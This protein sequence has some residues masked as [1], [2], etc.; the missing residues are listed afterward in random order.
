MPRTTDELVDEL[1]RFLP[2]RFAG[3]RELLAPVAGQLAHVLAVAELDFIEHT[4]V[5][6]ARGPWLT[7][8]ARGYGI[9]R[10]TGELDASVRLRLRFVE[11]A[12]TKPAIEGAVN[13][14]LAPYTSS[15]CEL[16]EHWADGVACDASEVEAAFIVDVSELYG[17]R[18]AFT[19]IVPLVADDP[20]HPVYNTIAAEVGR[21]KAAGVRWWMILEAP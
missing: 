15:T 20:T 7:L 8:L 10:A 19:L 2:E 5:T 17:A 9:R 11:D 21:L 1:L 13:A 14:L 4:T 6:G 16:V 12:Q 18:L 3:C